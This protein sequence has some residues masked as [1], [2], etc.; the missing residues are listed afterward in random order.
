[1]LNVPYPSR[2]T[3]LH[4]LGHAFYFGCTIYISSMS[5]I[6]VYVCSGFYS[7]PK[8]IV[9]VIVTESRVIDPDPGRN[10]TGM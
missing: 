6:L 3:V 7:H 8:V 10:T 5:A 1:M 4:T 9:I 2:Y